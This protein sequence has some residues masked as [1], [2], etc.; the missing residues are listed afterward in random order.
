MNEKN[1]KTLRA[2][3]EALKLLIEQG[4][5]NKIALRAGQQLVEKLLKELQRQK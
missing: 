2:L 3:N 1:L 4:I 5:T